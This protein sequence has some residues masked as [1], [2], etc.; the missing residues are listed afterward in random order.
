VL[1]GRRYEIWKALASLL[2]AAKR[3]KVGDGKAWISLDSLVRIE[4]Y[5]WVTSDFWW[6]YFCTPFPAVWAAR[7]PPVG[8]FAAVHAARSIPR[9][10]VLGVDVNDCLL[11]SRPVVRQSR[12]PSIHPA[13]AA[14]FW[15][16]NVGNYDSWIDGDG[17]TAPPP[18]RRQTGADMQSKYKETSLGGVAVNLV[19]CWL[20]QANDLK[21]RSAARAEEKTCCPGG[22]A[23]AKSAHYLSL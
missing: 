22:A 19:E 20:K 21:P 2:L 12:S 14:C 11:Q 4:T 13:G 18:H 3:V 6:K 7:A 23:S 10:D 16:E 17:W 8:R 15:Q 9:Q 1:G 5:Q